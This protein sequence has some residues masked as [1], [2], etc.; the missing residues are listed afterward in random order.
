MSKP[1]EIIVKI[2]SVGIA[3]VVGW[4]IAAMSSSGCIAVKDAIERQ[5][6]VDVVAEARAACDVVNSLC[7]VLEHEYCPAA[8]AIC[9]GLDVTMLEK[10]SLAEQRKELAEL[11]KMKRVLMKKNFE[12]NEQK[13]EG[14]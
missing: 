12:R 11:D 8:M 1:V 2:F 10:T 7:T 14:K 4:L 3:I 6:N 9:L 5:W 13:E